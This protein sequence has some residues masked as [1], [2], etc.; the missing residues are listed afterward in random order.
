MPRPAVLPLEASPRPTRVLAVL[1]PGAGRKWCSLSV[2]SVNLL[3]VHE[4]RDGVDHPAELRTIFLDDDVADALETQRAQRVALVLLAAGAGTGLGDLELGH[5]EATASA[6]VFASAM[7]CLP[8]LSRAAGATS[9]TVRPR[10]WATISGDSSRRSAA[11]VACTML[12]ALDEPSDLL[13]TSWMPAASS[14]ARTGPPAMTPV[15]GDAGRRNTTPAAFSPCTGCGM[16]P[17]MRGTRK[18]DFFA[19]STPLEMA[20]GTSLALP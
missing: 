4:M 2:I 20:V 5:R 15:P 19:S 8:A 11:T 6:S 14:T 12:M 16:V 3:D 9:S 7:P 13:S 10:R 17:W 1:A 18:K